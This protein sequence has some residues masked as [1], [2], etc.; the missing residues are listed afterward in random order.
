MN[1]QDKCPCTCC[2]ERDEAIRCNEGD[3]AA[4]MV[5]RDLR[6]SCWCDQSPE[7]ERCDCAFCVSVWIAGRLRSH[8]E[9]VIQPG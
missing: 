5:P 9:I 2:A 7:E 1:E 6:A 3:R 8:P 4:A